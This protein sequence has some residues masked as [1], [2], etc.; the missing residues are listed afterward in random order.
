MHIPPGQ[1]ID[2]AEKTLWK[3]QYMESYLKVIN[4]YQY[5]IIMILGAHAHPAEIRAPVSSRYPD[6]SLPILLTPSVT[7]IAFMMPS[8]TIM[9]FKPSTQRNKPSPYVTWRYLQLLD[10]IIYQLPSFTTL[11]PQTQYGMYISDVSSIRNFT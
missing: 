2:F 11:D 4:D 6:L 5:R 8:Y 3:D 7:P 9:N 10:Y 1:W